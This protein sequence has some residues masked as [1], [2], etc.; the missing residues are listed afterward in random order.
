MQGTGRWLLAG[1]VTAALVLPGCPMHAGGALLC[2][3]VTAGCEDGPQV[4]S[5]QR[6]AHRRCT[7]AEREGGY[8]LLQEVLPV[9]GPEEGVRHDLGRAF[10]SIA[11]TL[12]SLSLQQGLQQA[13]CLPA[14]VRCTQGSASVDGR[15]LLSLQAAPRLCRAQAAQLLHGK[16]ACGKD[17]A[18]PALDKPKLQ[19]EPCSKHADH[20]CI[21]AA[22]HPELCHVSRLVIAVSSGLILCSQIGLLQKPT[23]DLS[24]S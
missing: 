8:L 13:L 5:P 20:W 23:W 2:A 6:L 21:P 22:T 9:D 18:F 15:Q 3:A 19:E 24:A 14:Q 10:L 12:G 4:A 16:N 7:A 1:R 17:A 11:Q